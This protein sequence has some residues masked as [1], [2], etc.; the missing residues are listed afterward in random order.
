MCPIRLLICAALFAL[1]P[2]A[3]DLNSIKAEP[4]LNRRA[5]L[6][7]AYAEQSLD[8]AGKAFKAGEIKRADIRMEEVRTAVEL[9]CDSLRA[10]HRA[11][12]NN[13]YYKRV[14]LSMRTLLRHMD[15][16]VHLAPVE[17][18]ELPAVDK[19]VQ[20]LHD[21]ILTDIMSKRK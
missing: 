7:M 11:P 12:R 19:R 5:E 10:T 2:I 9:A 4:D 3:A 1:S 8:D 6:A 20:E 18:Q 17:D 13:K 21:Q 14:E 15:D 16:L